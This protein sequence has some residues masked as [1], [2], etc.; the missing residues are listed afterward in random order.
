M[1]EPLGLEHGLMNS[2]LILTQAGIGEISTNKSAR[3]FKEVDKYDQSSVQIYVSRS[4]PSLSLL[5]L[6]VRKFQTQPEL[7]MRSFILVSLAVT[8]AFATINIAEVN[9]RLA[10]GGA[11]FTEIGVTPGSESFAPAASSVA[12]GGGFSS[13]Q[14]IGGFSSSG[15][16]IVGGASSSAAAGPGKSTTKE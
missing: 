12:G 3:R 5:V 6:S 13:S 1:F 4:Q 16:I 10:S 9:R 2:H 8:G 14:G 11:S 7:I 15:G